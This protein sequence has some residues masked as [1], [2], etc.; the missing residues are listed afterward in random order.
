MVSNVCGQLRLSLIHICDLQFIDALRREY[1]D[2]LLQ[3]DAN[4]AYTLNHLPVFKK[5]DEYNLSLI[6]QPLGYDLSLIHI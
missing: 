6:E 4:S 5:M 2:M 1:P 3:V